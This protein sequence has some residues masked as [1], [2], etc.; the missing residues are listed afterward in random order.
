MNDNFLPKNN[1][2]IALKKKAL[3]NGI[4]EPVIVANSTVYGH[5]DAFFAKWLALGDMYVACD[6]DYTKKVEACKSS[7]GDVAYI[8]R[9]SIE[10]E[11]R[12]VNNKYFRIDNERKF[13]LFHGEVGFEF[14]LKE[15]V[16][17]V[18]IYMIV[19]EINHDQVVFVLKDGGQ[20]DPKNYQITSKS[21][22]PNKAVAHA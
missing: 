13:F 22:N 3:L 21:K 14:Q 5:T 20:V 12:K 17:G 16:N 19:N 7:F 18:H 8:K 1:N 15:I 4:F 10:C 9:T 11:K 2:T 6:N